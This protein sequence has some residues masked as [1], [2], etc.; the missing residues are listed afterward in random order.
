MTAEVT[1]RENDSLP[2]LVSGG[3]VVDRDA[4]A[5]G[6][7]YEHSKSSLIDSVNVGLACGQRLA[8]KKASMKHGEWLPW[9]DANAG[10][11]GF[12]S[13]FTA[14]KL[15]RAAQGNVPLA[16]HL[17]E[18]TAVKLSREMWGH[19]GEGNHLAQGTGENEWYTPPEFIALAREVMGGIDLDPASNAEANETVGAT[20]FYTAEDDGLEQ[21][22]HGRVWLNP[23]YSRDLMPKFM[24]KLKTE[25][26]GDNIRA[27]IV[28]THNNT[29]TGWFH[30][31]ADI[32]SAIC[33]ASKRIKFYR[34][35]TVAAP[36]NGQMFL[37]FGADVPAF[38]AA[39]APVGFVVVPA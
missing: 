33:F 26:E 18:S 22:W 9:L 5:I 20:E 1:I 21:Q 2:A 32:I 17:D 28:V 11:L 39:F 38:K 8:E 30:S 29:D 37:Y 16:A 3:E 31:L 19:K 10:V 24:D 15:I 25:Y 36:V 34:G 13:R 7:L 4:V 23:P 14:A 35:D 12:K 6:E 27:A